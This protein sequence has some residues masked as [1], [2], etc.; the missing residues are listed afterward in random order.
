VL[1]VRGIGLVPKFTD[2]YILN[3]MY[4][5]HYWIFTIIETNR[6]PEI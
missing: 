6:I 5:H 3:C 2:C 4:I 1:L